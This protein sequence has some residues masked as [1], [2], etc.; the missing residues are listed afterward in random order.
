MSD[1]RPNIV[2]IMSDQ[3]NPH[4]LGCAGDPVVRTPNL[5]ALAGRG[6]RFTNM[7][8]PYPLCVPSRMG[9]MTGQYPSEV[10]VWDNGSPLASSVPTFAHGLGAAGYEAVLCGRMHFVGPDQ[11]HGFERRIMS[12]VGGYMLTPEI[13]GDGAYRTNGQ[14]AYAVQVS[15]HGRCGYAAYEAEVTRRACDFLRER[16]EGE[17][18]YCLVVGLILPHNPLI[19]DKDL[20]DHYMSALGDAPETPEATQA[21]LHPA[22]RKWRERRWVD[23]ITPE[24]ARRG[25]AAYYGLVTQLDRNVGRILETLEASGSENTLV[26]YTSDHG[27]MN[28][29]HGMWW[30]SSFYEGSAGVPCLAAWP[31]AIA[32]GTRIHAVSNLIDLGPTVLDVAGAAPLPDAD[33]RS[34]AEFLRGG[35]PEQWPDETFCEYLGLLGDKP[36]SMIRSG[37]WKLNYYHEFQSYQLFN[38]EDDPGELND[39]RGDPD[40]RD[41]ADGLLARIHGRW[42]AERTLERA[43]RKN[44]SVR[45]VHECGHDLFPHGIE[46]WL[47]PPEENVFDLDQ[48][49]RKP[50][51]PRR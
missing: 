25:R 23:D 16:P 41:V 31:G 12:D 18:P 22:M 27:D 37:P 30:K 51:P 19:C 14:T 48:L 39:L 40:L 24:E 35:A 44:R 17:R 20:F 45:Y 9:F 21:R 4:V 6:A 11:F 36:G 15:G 1:Q 47:A 38:L 50:T 3:H 2:L 8:C 43:E 28:G 32:P 34:L 5:D 13:L 33:G 42:S 10:D 29:E 49:P 7:Y 46:K 26:L